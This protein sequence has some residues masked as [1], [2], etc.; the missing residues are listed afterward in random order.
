ATTTQGHCLVQFSNRK[1]LDAQLGILR[2]HFAC[3]AVP[4]H[5]EHLGLLQ[6]E[7]AEY[8][9]GRR[10]QFQVPLVYPGTP[11][12]VKVWDRLRQIP[13]GNTISYEALAR[14]VGSPNAQR[15]VGLANGK[16]RI[17][18]VI[19]CHRVVNKSGRL[20]GYGG[21]VWRKEYLLDLERQTCGQTLL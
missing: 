14:H 8:F 7:L 3:T 17:G 20:G 9:T 15:A 10:T 1:V 16:N 5:N 19:P 4:G 6:A 2:K 21:G 12:Q 11:F 18:I 13:Y